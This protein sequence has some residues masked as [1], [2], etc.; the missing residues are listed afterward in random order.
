MEK[1][2]VVVIGAGN[3]GMAAAVA[4]AQNG[5]KPLVLERHRMPGGCAT[6]FVRGR[7]EFDASIHC[8]FY[9]FQGYQDVWEGY[10]NIDPNLVE[11]KTGVAYSH[12]DKDGK[13]VL[14]KY[15]HGDKAFTEEFKR[16]F[17]EDADKI[18]ELMSIARSFRDAVTI[19]SGGGVTV[20][21]TL[22]KFAQIKGKI[23]M[24]SLLLKAKK[25]CPDFLKLA[26]M[27]IPEFFDEYNMPVSVRRYIGS[28]WWYLGDSYYKL[29]IAR[30][31]G[32][33]YF[34]IDVPC[35]YPVNAC[36]E[37][38]MAIESKLREHGG[39]IRYNEEVTDIII[40]DGKVVGVKTANG[41]EIET[42]Y[43]ISNA[44]AG[45]VFKKMIRDDSPAR[46]NLLDQI[47]N[48]PFNGSF[49]T[50]YLGLNA[51]CEELGIT[52]HH[53]YF[54]DDDD[55]GKTW[56][57]SK[58]FGGPYSFGSLC[59]NVTIPEFSPEGTCVFTLTVSIRPEALEGM[60]QCEYEKAKMQFASDL[61]DRASYHLGFN[62]RDYIEEIEV[63][64]PVTL[65][66]YAN[67]EGGAL[68]Y[69]LGSE[70]KANVKA[71]LNDAMK[72]YK[73]LSFIGQYGTNGIGYSNSVDGYKQGCHQA[74]VIK[75]GK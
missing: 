55:G 71:M 74:L 38:L 67:A 15:P 26:K 53:I 36:H 19:M 51:S 5:L 6:S 59:P 54:T 72:N 17:P 29:P 44:S 4:L 9:G 45:T 35:Y 41:T 58:T 7:F 21:K 14:L 52:N 75:G 24:L 57:A 20:D 32:S 11:V 69:S 49:A 70:E 1:R 46:K 16:Q 66:R 25:V 18:D 12:L 64:T 30:M 47:H 34:P 63:M 61:V 2:S 39:E 13:P 50:V 40:K 37:Y 8:L 68:G 33:F 73:G 10:M 23:R 62:L 42:N 56:E 31:L 48:I 22:S 28:L 27:T 65:S 3:G 43:V 60:S